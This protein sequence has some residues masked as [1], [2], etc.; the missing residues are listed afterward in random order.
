MVVRHPRRNPI[1]T[2]KPATDGTDL[3]EW[4]GMGRSN[5][6]RPQVIWRWRGV[7]PARRQSAAAPPSLHGGI[8]PEHDAL[9]PPLPGF[10]PNLRKYDWK[11]MGKWFNWLFTF[12]YAITCPICGARWQ[13]HGGRN[14][15]EKL[16]RLR[17]QPRCARTRQSFPACLRSP[18]TT[19][20]V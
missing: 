7:F 3:I 8:P 5:L 4:R 13:H 11:D 20:L 17:P 12:C 10:R 2:A 15:V 19:P 16:P 18:R 1:S 6:N 14:S 9:V